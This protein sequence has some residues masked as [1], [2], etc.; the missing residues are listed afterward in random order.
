M[1][2]NA[3]QL[4][5]GFL[6]FL[7]SQASHSQYSGVIDSLQAVLSNDTTSRITQANIYAALGLSYRFQDSVKAFEYT[8]LAQTFSREIKYNQGIV[9]A[10]L[11]RVLLLADYGNYDS[12]F[13]YLKAIEPEILEIGSENQKAKVKHYFGLIWDRKGAF[14]EAISSYKEAEQ[15]FIEIGDS[16]ELFWSVN[17]ISN[18]FHAT[19]ETV[20]ALEYN[21]RAI[22]IAKAIDDK[23]ALSTSYLSIGTIYTNL[24]NREKALRYLELSESIGTSIGLDDIRGYS[25]NERAKLYIDQK[26]YQKALPL[27]EEALMLNR[28]LKNQ[29][30]ESL[31]FERIGFIKYK[32][33]LYDQSIEYL[34][35][36]LQISRKI[37]DQYSKAWV[38][39]QLGKT[40]LADGKYKNSEESL[41]EALHLAN[42]LEIPEISAACYGSFALLYEKTGLYK[43]SIASYKQFQQLSDS[44]TNTKKTKLF[45]QLEAEYN[46]N[47]AMD[48][49]KYLQREESNALKRDLSERKSI[50]QLAL[51]G[52]FVSIILLII[53][54]YI[55]RSNQR[56]KIQLLHLNDRIEKQSNDIKQKNNRLNKTNHELEQTVKTKSRFFSIISH[57]LRNPITNMVSLSGVLAKH[58]NDQQKVSSDPTLAA[59]LEH[60]ETSAFQVTN[61]FDDLLNWSMKE[62]GAINYEPAEMAIKEEVES[63]ISILIDH[64]TKKSIA[65]ETDIENNLMGWLDKNSF[66]CIMRNLISNAIKFTEKGGKISIRAQ[67]DSDNLKLFVTDSGIGIPK[68]KMKTLFIIEE[69]K[70]SRGTNGEKGTGLGLSLVCD[71]VKMNK[72]TVQVESTTD[73]GTTFTL[74]FPKHQQAGDMDELTQSSV[75]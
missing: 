9:V 55:N 7:S 58:L 47:A 39:S 16:S 24:E 44:L 50:L 42:A 62:E 59:F 15:L 34:Q 46:F 60:L 72:G 6:F 43:E 52:L 53:I 5:V 51:V 63:C 17:N 1:C 12:A 41:T 61:L 25:L 8:N 56:A 66:R 18:I 10:K 38:L 31:S 30:E 32:L 3:I 74:T 67:T 40:Y 45:A 36:S 29:A 57:D 26:D 68:D 27:L 49:L 48:S 33:G 23:E 75:A 37:N 13:S 19:G 14:N 4:V 65:I 70:V 11:N 35:Q 21:L 20:L 22:D 64:A 71:F 54:Y 69:F 73:V 28:L 2:K